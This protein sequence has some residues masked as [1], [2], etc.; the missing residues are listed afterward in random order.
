[1][2][3]PVLDSERG[4]NLIDMGIADGV[5]VAAVVEEED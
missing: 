2:D 5:V 3:N 4:S 1:M